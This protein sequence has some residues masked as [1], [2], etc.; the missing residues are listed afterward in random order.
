M[1]NALS[2]YDWLLKFE[3]VDWPIGDLAKDVKNDD[4]FP[5]KSKSETEIIN[6]LESRHAHYAA[7]ETAKECFNFYKA[8]HL[9][10]HLE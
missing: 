10:D 7:I 3:S 1:K 5:K 9:D 6:Y 4:A 2:F 8:S